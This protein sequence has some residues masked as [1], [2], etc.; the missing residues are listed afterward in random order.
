MFTRPFP[1]LRAVVLSV[2]AAAAG[3]CVPP[4]ARLISP[5]PTP[6]TILVTPL[7][8]QSPSS[9]FDPIVATDTL[10]A[11]L[12]QVE[13]LVVL[14]TNRALKPLVARG[15]TAVTSIAEAMQLAGEVGAD[16][17]L[18]GA[19]TD[20]SPYSPQKVGMTLQLHWVRAD[21]TGGGLDP[22]REGR[23]ASPS[24]AT[25]SVSRRAS[26]VQAVLDASR[27]DVVTWVEAYASSH[28]GQDSPYG[29]RKYLVDSD[30]YMHFV[31]HEMI[32]RLLNAE[33]ER[34]TA[35]VLVH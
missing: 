28:R 7:L 14:P 29:W 26:Q 24:G 22:V 35:P 25:G 27:D 19:I 6:R 8:N 10:V 16:G 12:S 17:V 33:L 2:V 1:V 13:G 4:D 3:G 31:C 21:M 20:Y 5:Y 9:D 23:L 18:V 34:I 11:E 30:A 15:K 32:V